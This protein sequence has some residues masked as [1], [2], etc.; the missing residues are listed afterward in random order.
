M[1]Y[2]GTNRPGR[3]CTQPTS[4]KA[5]SMPRQLPGTDKRS[6]ARADDMRSLPN[7]P[8]R[9]SAGS[10]T[11]PPPALCVGRHPPRRRSRESARGRG[12]VPREMGIRGRCR[13]EPHVVRGGGPQARQPGR[14]RISAAEIA[15]ILERRREIERALRALPAGRVPGRELIPWGPLAR[16][17]G[18]S[19]GSAASGFSKMTKALHKKRPALILPMLDS[20]VQAYLESR[21]SRMD[22]SESS[23]TALVAATRWTDPKPRVLRAVQARAGAPGATRSPRC[24]CSIS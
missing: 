4:W 24:G 18:A 22:R 6:F 10:C 9:A 3:R 15:A 14:R 11:S 16:L 1:W 23:A 13:C 17:F 20:V 2:D 21:R 7:V 8:A 12:R 19:P 5:R